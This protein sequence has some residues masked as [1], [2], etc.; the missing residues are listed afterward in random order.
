MDSVLCYLINKLTRE[1]CAI[2]LNEDNVR[3]TKGKKDIYWLALGGTPIDYELLERTLVD[4]RAELRINNFIER[5][6]N[7]N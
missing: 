6:R 5:A 1:G 3:V 2:E 7:G 4:A